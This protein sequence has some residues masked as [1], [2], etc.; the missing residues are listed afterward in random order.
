MKPKMTHHVQTSN[1]AKKPDIPENSASAEA[2]PDRQVEEYTRDADFTWVVS[3][4]MAHRDEILER[5]LDA[6]AKQP[7]HFDRKESAVADHIP[8]LVDALIGLLR[9]TTPSWI[10]S[11]SPLEDIAILSAA[12]SH[13]RERAEQ[14][15]KP[16]DVVIEFRLLRQEI[17]RALREA[18][19]DGAPT[20]GVVAAEML[21]NDALDGAISQGLAALTDHVE[22]VREEF[23][24]TTMH[25][26]RQPLTVISGESQIL[27]RTLGNNNP[28]LARLCTSAGRIKASTERMT[29]LLE[30]LTDVSRMALGDLGLQKRSVRLEEVIQKAL[31]NC[32]PDDKNRVVLEIDLDVDTTGE[33][34]P[35]RLEQV[36]GN[37]VGNALKYS[38]SGT[39]VEI[40]VSANKQSVEFSVRD[41]GIG[42]PPED[43]KRLF[44]RYTR[45]GNAIEQGI[46]GLGLGL[47]LCRGIVN[48]HGGRIF[49]QSGGSG[50]GT[51]VTVVLPRH[52]RIAQKAQMAQMGR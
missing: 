37:L 39:P 1:T 20:D 33:W 50:Q 5:W 24:A 17:W 40:K 2:I 18:I 28:D 27:I 47:Y 12:L 29:S 52:A 46:E 4:L 8:R 51:T 31:L 21:I 15:L 11:S 22:Q 41:Y 7:F 6:A 36:V 3:A 49:A 9:T 10:N 23:L 48:A 35:T 19:P 34:D 26:V 25:E 38:P 13:A 30:T 44:S 32:P 43:I 16:A 45:A 14:G 42:V